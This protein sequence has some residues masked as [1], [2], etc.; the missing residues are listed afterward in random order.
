[1]FASTSKITFCGGGVAALC[2]SE[3][4]IKYLSSKA[5]AQMICPDKIN[6]MRHVMFLKDKEGIKAQMAKHRKIIKP[7]FE[8]VIEGLEKE[9]G[10]T[11]LA[12]WT[13]PR[14]GYFISLYAPD[15]CAKKTVALAAEAG[16]ELTPAGS[17]Y[18]YKKDPHDNNIR[19]SPTFPSVEDLSAAVK[20]LGIC[21][22]LAYIEKLINS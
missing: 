18:P 10:H 8:A 3:K 13:N 6:Q 12:R 16:L 19:I 7:K 21:V 15:N 9:L 17:T 11:G 1:M 22:K 2:A 14:G 4:N 20:L 5:A